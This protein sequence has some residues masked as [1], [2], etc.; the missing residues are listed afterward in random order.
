MPVEELA[1]GVYGWAGQEGVRLRQP[2]G[3]GG[4]GSSA[5]QLLEMMTEIRDKASSTQPAQGWVRDTA[6]T[7]SHIRLRIGLGIPPQ[8]DTAWQVFL[9][10]RSA[11]EDEAALTAAG[12]E[13][14]VT[15]GSA[16]RPLVSGVPVC[17]VR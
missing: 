4:G 2:I 5:P 9:G 6:V 10:V 15:V 3:S 8:C 14:I 12:I 13:Q 16:P 11:A 1:P 17:S 7:P